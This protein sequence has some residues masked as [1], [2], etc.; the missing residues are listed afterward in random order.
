M[1]IRQCRPRGRTWHLLALVVPMLWL[2]GCESLGYLGQ[3]VNGQIRLLKARQTV[4]ELLAEQDTSVELKERLELALSLLEF[5]SE[6]LALDSGK[7]Y[8]HYVEL[9]S[10]YV[11]WS[12]FVAPRFSVA[13]LQWCFPVAGCV[14]YR[15]YFKKKLALRYAEKHK[16]VG[17][18]AVVVGITGYSTLG[19]FAD[20]LLSSFPFADAS[21]LATLLF[22]E[23]SHSLLY[24]PNDSNFNES[25]ATVVEQI[26]L[27]RWLKSQQLEKEMNK[28]HQQALLR[29]EFSRFVTSYRH[30]LHALYSSS[31]NPEKLQLAKEKIFTNMRFAYRQRDWGSKRYD[32]FMAGELNNA[33]LNLVATYFDQ[34]APLQQLLAEEGYDLPAFYAA[35]KALAKL[36]P[37]ARQEQIKALRLRSQ[38]KSNHANQRDDCGTNEV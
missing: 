9:S 35:A 21:Q 16:Q 7:N 10:R 23:L 24:V 29:A 15:G 33:T 28:Y 6:Q 5:A 22:H 37:P 38:A 18:D 14:P 12:V 32:A 3:A 25:F 36:K 8:R 31:D 2:S 13:P 4:A 27:C 11:S 34:V 26:G 19:F 1:T 17:H 20:P 30:Q